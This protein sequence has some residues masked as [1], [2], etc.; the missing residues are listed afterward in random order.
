MVLTIYILD[1][2]IYKEL[3]LIIRDNVIMTLQLYFLRE[4]SL[5]F[6]IYT[7][8]SMVTRS[9]CEIIPRYSVF[10]S[11]CSCSVAQL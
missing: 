6:N 2:E 9:L 1:Q 4:A 7:E 10:C 3:L 11:S 5:S 8:M